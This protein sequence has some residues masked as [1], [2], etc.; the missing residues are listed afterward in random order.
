MTSLSNEEYDERKRFLEDLKKLVKEEQENIYRILK[1][2]NE[3]FSENSNGIFFDLTKV[4][5]NTFQQMKSY[6]EFC[7]KNRENFTIREEEERKAQQI[8]SGHD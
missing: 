7:S 5:I 1:Q 8:L 3:D 2:S 6:M 4:K